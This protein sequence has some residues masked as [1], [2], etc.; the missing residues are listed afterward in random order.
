MAVE[1]W[2]IIHKTKER[3]SLWEVTLENVGRDRP[4]G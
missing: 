1:K 4:F 3:R 2:D